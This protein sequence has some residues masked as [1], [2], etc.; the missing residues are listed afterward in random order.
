MQS[1]ESVVAPRLITIQ[2]AAKVL[3][4]TT[5]NVRRLIWN[6]KL[7]YVKVGKRFNIPVEALEI[8]V[9]ENQRRVGKGSR[10]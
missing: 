9:S 2:E 8:F 5:W 7:P 4:G 1:T 6:G 10:A 3:G